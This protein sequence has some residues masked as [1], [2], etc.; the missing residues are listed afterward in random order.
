[1]NRLPVLAALLWFAA[2]SA[3]SQ[4]PALP[5]RTDP[6][7]PLDVDDPMRGPPERVFVSP[8]GEPFR[9]P[10][11]G[12]YPSAEWFARADTDRDG[13][14][15]ITEFTADALSFFDRIDANSDGIVDG[16]E[17]ADYERDV[18][19]E[20]TGVLRRPEVR[21]PGLLGGWRAP[22]RGDVMWGRSPMLAPG[23]RGDRAP[24]RRQGA[25][26]YGLLNE[27]HPVRAADHD[28]DGKVTRAEAEAAARRRFGLLDGDR[29][30]RLTVEGLPR[31]PAQTAFGETMAPPA[32]RKP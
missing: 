21:R 32:G 26:Q 24:P 13:V 25:A 8:A 10:M 22:S 27:P 3:M 18:A 4:P 16:F 19:P 20:I 11:D 17:N 2:G 1:M 29:D 5:Q 23:G 7:P 31:T 30:G 9:A 6:A 12:P 14:L 28:F 15:T